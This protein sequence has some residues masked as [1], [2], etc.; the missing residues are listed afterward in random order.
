MNMPLAASKHLGTTVISTHLQL[1]DISPQFPV[2]LVSS[3]LEGAQGAPVWLSVGGN[4]RVLLRSMVDAEEEAS[5][6]YADSGDICSE[7]P[8]GK[9]VQLG[10]FPT[11][12]PHSTDRRAPA[13]AE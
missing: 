9:C 6:G 5:W 8:R 2:F 3:L 7:Q 4:L 1:E 11:K 10:W 12:Q 13:G